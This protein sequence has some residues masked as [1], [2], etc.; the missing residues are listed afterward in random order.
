MIELAPYQL[1]L[2]CLG[3]AWLGVFIGVFTASMCV[4]AGRR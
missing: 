3:S 4:A 1:A 2:I